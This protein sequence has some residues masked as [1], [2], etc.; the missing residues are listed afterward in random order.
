[1]TLELYQKTGIDIRNLLAAGRRIEAVS[2]YDKLLN[3]FVQDCWLTGIEPYYGNMVKGKA[4]V[5]FE[6]QGEFIK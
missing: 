6:L 3:V 1:M 4:N 5:L 2:L